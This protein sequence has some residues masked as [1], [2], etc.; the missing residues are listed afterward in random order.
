MPDFKTML[1]P[2]L[3]ITMLFSCG[4]DS[5]ERVARHLELAS[6]YLTAR[7]C[8]KA[9]DI[10]HSI[11]YQAKNALYLQIYA[12]AYACR[13]GFFEPTFFGTDLDKISATQTGFI[14]SLTTFSTSSITGTSDKT[15][16]DLWAAVKTLIYAGVNSASSSSRRE[17]F[18]SSDVNDMDMQALYMLLALMGKYFNFFGNVNSS[19]T[20]GQ[21]S[22]TNGCLIDYNAP[23]DAGNNAGDTGSCD[24]DNEG[25]TTLTGDKTAR[26]EGITL[27]N[28]FVDIISNITLPGTNTGDLGN[29]SGLFST[30]CSGDVNIPDSS[31][32]SIRDVSACTQLGDNTIEIYFMYIFEKNFL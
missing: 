30:L 8:D 20:K 17:V 31:V 9:L 27:F 5:D 29:L 25:N 15:Y 2:I 16:T 19:G 4:E 22:G 1:I 28:N 6:E 21:G 3:L 12:S 7:D 24:L 11:G 10:L 26:C 14:G 18:S 13:A 32:C 23:A